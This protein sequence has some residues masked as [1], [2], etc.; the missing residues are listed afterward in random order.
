MYAPQGHACVIRQRAGHHPVC[1][2]MQAA[3]GQ[4]QA[5]EPRASTAVAAEGVHSKAQDIW[6]AVPALVSGAP[7]A[8]TSTLPTMISQL[9]QSAVQ[10]AL[11]QVGSQDFPQECPLPALSYHMV[12][13]GSW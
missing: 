1:R 12:T 8:V 9:V 13:L 7:P 10:S 5:A 4:C 3:A 6:G 2:V 11:P